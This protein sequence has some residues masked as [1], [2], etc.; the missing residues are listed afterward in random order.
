MQPRIIITMCIFN[1]MTEMPFPLIS[2][3]RYHFLTTVHTIILFLLISF[4]N[5]NF[6]SVLIKS[7]Y[8]FCHN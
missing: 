2:L 4:I 5:I 7:D 3:N 8:K 6:F 1:F